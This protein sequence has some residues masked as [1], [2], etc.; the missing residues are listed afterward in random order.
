DD[1]N[2]CTDDSCQPQT[3]CQNLPNTLKC[4]D[5]NP[6]TIGDQCQSS[7]CL[8]G[9]K[10]DCDDG[11]PCTVDSCNETT[12]QCEHDKSPCDDG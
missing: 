5:G 2:P 9:S 1:K 12:A 11:T 7:F 4:S 6:C 3:G 10:K 8:S